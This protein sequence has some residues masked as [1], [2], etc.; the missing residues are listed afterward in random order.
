MSIFTG[1]VEEI[2]IVEKLFVKSSGGVIRI[3][4]RKVLEGTSIGDSI[5]VNGACLT[6]RGLY[7]DQ[8]EMDIM[9]ETLRCTSLDQLRKGSK[10]NMERAIRADSRF[11]GHILT[12]HIDTVCTVKRRYSEGG[13]VWLGIECTQKGN[14]V[15]KGS[16]A[17]DGVSLTVAKMDPGLVWVSLIPHTLDT[18][19]LLDLRIG[20]RCNIEYDILSKYAM[21]NEKEE[22]TMNRLIESGF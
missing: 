17:I 9:P 2:G 1:I 3:R 4:A 14:L 5:A 20:D 13:T 8:V 15:Q 18:T 21:A 6:V 11:G 16:I 7:T 19:T 10:V 22:L 12:G